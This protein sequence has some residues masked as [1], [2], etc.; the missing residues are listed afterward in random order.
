M[1]SKQLII[2]ELYSLGQSSSS[3]SL[4]TPPEQRSSIVDKFICSVGCTLSFIDKHYK[5]LYSPNTTPETAK[6]S[7]L[8]T[9]NRGA[10]SA[11]SNSQKLKVP[12][13]SIQLNYRE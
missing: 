5:P 11:S 12:L 2:I 7:I 4:Y 6:Y 8:D 1:G 9:N 10:D 13:V 3:N